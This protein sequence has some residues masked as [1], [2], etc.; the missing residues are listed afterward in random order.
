[1]GELCISP[2]CYISAVWNV[3]R[4]EKRRGE[5]RARVSF[6]RLSIE[7]QHYR[8]ASSSFAS[9]ALLVRLAM[10][11]WARRA[12]HG[13][14]TLREPL[15]GRINQSP[16]W[17]LASVTFFARFL[18]LAL[19]LLSAR[20]VRVSLP[21]ARERGPPP[22]PPPPPPPLDPFSIPSSNRSRVV[23]AE[24]LIRANPFSPL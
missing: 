12:A 8:D 20:F 11:L 10:H 13:C 6:L 3:A 9:G 7:G 19:P 4:G 2:R 1:M 18:S 14:S 22:P 16:P 5:K 23:L 24:F 21:R 17:R 15:P